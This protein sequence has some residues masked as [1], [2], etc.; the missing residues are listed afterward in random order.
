ME[1]IIS[2]NSQVHDLGEVNIFEESYRKYMNSDKKKPLKIFIKKS[3][4]IILN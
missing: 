1:S 3:K 4:V 2:L